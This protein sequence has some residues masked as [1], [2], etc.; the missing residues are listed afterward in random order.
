MI[1]L[2]SNN[3]LSQQIMKMVIKPPKLRSHPLIKRK[4]YQASTQLRNLFKSKLKGNYLWSQVKRSRTLRRLKS[5]RAKL[6]I[7]KTNK[8]TRQRTKMFRWIKIRWKSMPTLQQMVPTVLILECKAE[9]KFPPTSQH[10]A[11]V[12]HTKIKLQL[13][14]PPLCLVTLLVIMVTKDNLKAITCHLACLKVLKWDQIQFILTKLEVETLSSTKDVMFSIQ[15][16]RLLPQ[17]FTYTALYLLTASS[18]IKNFALRLHSIRAI[19]MQAA[20]SKQCTSPQWCQANSW[21]S[22]QICLQDQLKL[23]R[24][25][26]CKWCSHRQQSRSTTT[27]KATWVNSKWLTQM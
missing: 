2:K 16:S 6:I 13:A 10:L 25:H 9:P 8:Q 11:K 20:A 18:R 26:L 24:L 27:Y 21:S 22:I 19:K 14:A 5:T 3:R 15:M 12:F 1:K 17:Q 7:F 4:F 23:S